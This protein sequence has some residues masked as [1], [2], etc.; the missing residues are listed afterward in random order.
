[1]IINKIIE[2]VYT[3]NRK[4]MWRKRNSHNDTLPANNFIFEHVVVGKYTYGLLNVID[5][6][7]NG[8]KLYIG[9]YCSVAENV[10]FLLNAEHSKDLF[11]TYPVMERVLHEP[12]IGASSKGDIIVHDDVWIG[13]GSIINSGIEIGQG[14]IIAAGSVVTKNIPPY[15]IVG[16]N[17]AKL[18]KYRTNEECQNILKKINLS[19]LNLE[20]FQKYREI[21][22]EK[23]DE[24][25]L[26]K[27]HEIKCGQKEYGIKTEIKNNI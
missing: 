2:R 7:K 15:A 24:N 5:L 4:K 3:Y 27:F 20:D 14:A 25:K 26:I 21:F 17:P 12:D 9:N 13:Y 11:L 23:L 1:M 16:G 6:N 19:T 18:I 10:T 8:N 22:I